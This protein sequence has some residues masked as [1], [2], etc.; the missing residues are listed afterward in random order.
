[1][2]Y[3]VRLDIFEGP[4]DLLVYLIE[5]SGLSIYDVNISE[6]TDQYM[7]HVNE[8][9]RIDPAAAAEFMVLAATLIQIKSKMLLPSDK[10]KEAAPAGADPRDEL[11][12]KLEEYRKVKYLASQLRIKEEEAARVFTKPR[13]DMSQYAPCVELEL[14]TDTF[15]DAFKAFLEKRR[16][17]EEVRR[18]YE[19]IDRDRMSMEVKSERIRQKIRSAVNMSFTQL[20]ED[21]GDTYDIVLTFVTMLEMLKSGMIKV[22]QDATFGDMTITSV[23]GPPQME[24]YTENDSINADIPSPYE[25][26]SG[27]AE[28]VTPSD[29]GKEQAYN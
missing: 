16:R 26:P 25:P 19:R 4:F 24:K 1:M 22:T 20:L 8:M 23:E 13:E 27:S 2:S 18:R 3:K 14:D 5:R 21:A 7:Y 15:I 6:I 11:A 17:M 10:P 12:R 28:A 9:N 29:A